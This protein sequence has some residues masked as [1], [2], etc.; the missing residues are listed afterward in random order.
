MARLLA[1]KPV[2]KEILGFVAS[3]VTT[4]AW[5]TAV[6]ATSKPCSAMEFFNSG[7]SILRLAIGSAGNEVELPYFILPG[8][9][10]GPIPL[11]IPKGV[12]LSLKAADASSTTGY[13]VFNFLA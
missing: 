9:T 5:V 10:F 2:A 11:V 8:G 13:C 1:C 7:G 3:N 4:S 6:A 12:R